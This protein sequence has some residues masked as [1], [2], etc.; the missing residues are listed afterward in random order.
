MSDGPELKSVDSDPNLVGPED[1][2]NL[3]MT[4]EGAPGSHSAVFG[5]TPDGKKHETTSST[6]TAPVPT[7]E[8]SAAGGGT[9]PDSAEDA[10]DTSSTGASGAGVAGQIDDPTLAAKNDNSSAGSGT[11]ILETVKSYVSGS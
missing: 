5:L 9:V 3:K 4:G 6:T 7:E 11:G 1:T 10:N 8:R 2:H